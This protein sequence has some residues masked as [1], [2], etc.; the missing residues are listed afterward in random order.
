MKEINLTYFLLMGL[1]TWRLTSMLMSEAGPF[2]I[3]VKFR[4]LFGIRHYDDG[5]VLSYK[6][7]FFCKLLQC[8][9]CCS[10]WVG[11]GFAVL[12]FFLPTVAIYFA[13]PFAF[14]TI[15]ILLQEHT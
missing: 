9:W 13:L 3:F 14:S 8:V 10:V 12:H 4:E 5:S 11:A 15:A 6:T 2:D 1:A 7:N